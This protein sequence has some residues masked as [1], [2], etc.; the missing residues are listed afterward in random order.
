[1]VIDDYSGVFCHCRR[2]MVMFDG[3]V[4]VHGGRCGR[5]PGS[6]AYSTLQYSAVWQLAEKP[7]QFLH[8]ETEAEESAQWF[9]LQKWLQCTRS[10]QSDGRMWHGLCICVLDFSSPVV[11]LVQ[12]EGAYRMYG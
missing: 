10:R 8:M 2:E 3:G 9:L 11:P 4:T 6:R 12:N 5:G 7:P 1:M